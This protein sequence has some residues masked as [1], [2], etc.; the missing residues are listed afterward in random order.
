MQ[1][2]QYLELA[3]SSFNIKTLLQSLQVTAAL[4]LHVALA[5]LTV[6]INI[7]E[8][9]I[10]FAMYSITPPYVIVHRRIDVRVRIRFFV[11]GSCT[12]KD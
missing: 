12:T 11:W 8:G 6:H 7:E 1:S 3:C 2:L 9:V 10:S 4:A 5:K